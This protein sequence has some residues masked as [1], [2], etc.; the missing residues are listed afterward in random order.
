MKIYKFTCKGDELVLET[1]VV[2]EAM[3]ILEEEDVITAETQ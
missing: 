3:K 1:D 2:E